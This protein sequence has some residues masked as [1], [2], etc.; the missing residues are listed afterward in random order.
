MINEW[1]DNLDDDDIDHFYN[2]MVNG[3]MN[4]IMD[5]FRYDIEYD[6]YNEYDDM[7]GLTNPHFVSQFRHPQ[8]SCGAHFGNVLG[9]NSM[10]IEG[11][12]YHGIY[13]YH[14]PAVFMQN[15]QKTKML[16]F[17]GKFKGQEDNDGDLVMEDQ[18]VQNVKHFTEQDFTS[19]KGTTVVPGWVLGGFTIET[20]G[21]IEFNLKIGAYDVNAGNAPWARQDDQTQ[22]GNAEMESLVEREFITEIVD[23]WKKS[24]HYL[25]VSVSE[26]F[27]DFRTKVF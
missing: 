19:G 16:R 5:A 11:H 21:H 9:T 13:I 25:F 14:S 18:D 24:V 10:Y 17:L 4:D 7:M 3:Q 1:I 12:R 20:D 6:D 23:K 22:N 2:L 27:Y 26:V 8:A 15:D